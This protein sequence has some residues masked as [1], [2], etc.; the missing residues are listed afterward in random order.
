MDDVRLNTIILTTTNI[1]TTI[2]LAVGRRIL[3]W[4][5]EKP[6]AY[7]TNH[8]TQIRLPFMASPARTNDHSR[9]SSNS[10][11]G[12][13]Q[14]I[15][16]LPFTNSSSPSPSLPRSGSDYRAR[17][18]STDGPDAVDPSSTGTWHIHGSDAH[19]ILRGRATYGHSFHRNTHHEARRMHRSMHHE[20]EQ[21]NGGTIILNHG[22][23]R[24]EGSPWAPLWVF[25]G[26]L[27]GLLIGAVLAWSML[28][29]RGS[30]Y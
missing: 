19:I 5:I 6:I 29:I 18:S 15:R 30:V 7:A 2:I 28:R 13:R 17:H 12:R 4:T 9:D 3:D 27:A 21:M 24:H 8:H 11:R 16:V 20:I 10:S 25:L 1:L 22:G 26:S 23:V 14:L